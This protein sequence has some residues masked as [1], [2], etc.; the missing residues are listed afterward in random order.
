MLVLSL[1]SDGNEDVGSL[2]LSRLEAINDQAQ[3]KGPNLS[4]IVAHERYARPS[5]R[6]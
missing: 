1:F 6:W 4:I 5:P 2:N 3:K